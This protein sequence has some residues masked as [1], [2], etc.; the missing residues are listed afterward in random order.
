MNEHNY[1]AIIQTIQNKG[2]NYTKAEWKNGNSRL[3]ESVAA[4]NIRQAYMLTIYKRNYARRIRRVDRS[5]IQ[6]SNFA[7]RTV[8]SIRRVSAER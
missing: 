4:A 7:V 3:S 6:D 8:P 5:P 2:K 1:T